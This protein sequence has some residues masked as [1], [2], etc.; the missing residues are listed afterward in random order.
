MYTEALGRLIDPSG[1]QTAFSQQWFGGS[2][3]CDSP[4]LVAYGQAIYG[5]QE[6]LGH[7]LNTS[8]ETL[9]LFRGILNREPDLNGFTE[10]KGMLDQGST[11]PNV[12]AYMTSNPT[13]AFSSLV[14]SICTTG[15]YGFGNVRPLAIPI[16]HTAD[17]CGA[18][19]GQTEADLQAQ[20]HNLSQAGGESSTWTRWHS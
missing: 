10:I 5:S 9:T 12:I 1:W 2:T 18:Y 16:A 6:Y 14:P 7:G 4:I 13:Y 20:I 8:A 19:C 17:F 3:S 11:I 15:S